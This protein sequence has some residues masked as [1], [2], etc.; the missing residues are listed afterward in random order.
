MDGV[1]GKL[2]LA[3]IGA[4]YFVLASVVICFPRRAIKRDGDV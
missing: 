1:D 3:V 4:V 2:L